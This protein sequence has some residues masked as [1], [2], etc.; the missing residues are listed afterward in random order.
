MNTTTPRNTSRDGVWSSLALVAAI[1]VGGVLIF[2][3]YT[4]ILSPK[5]FVASVESY[6][7]LPS[8]A[9]LP[10][11]TGLIGL[12]IAL[13]LLLILGPGRRVAA[14]I[15][16]PL[17]LMFIAMVSYAMRTGLEECGCFGEVLKMEPRQELFVDLV[18]LGLTGLVLW[19]GRSLE[20]GSRLVAPTLGW[21][22][23]V[24][25]AA[26]FLAAGPAVSS[27]EELDLRWSDLSVLEQA[28]P[29]L[30]L[31]EDA[32]LFFFAADCDHCWAFAGAV[33]LMH[34]RVEGLPVHAITF[35]DRLSLDA[36]RDAFQPTY[37]IHVLDRAVFDRLVATYPAGV[38]IQAG[39]I[40]QTWAGFVPSHRQIAES[41]GYL[42]RETPAA[43]LG[44][45]GAITEESPT[46]ALPSFGGTLSGRSRQ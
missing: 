25:G 12:E 26:I 2:S 20:L 38:W 11:T 23:L 1:L 19:K 32:F 15:T 22:G 31:G 10:G 39:G 46:S 3:A 4:K 42:Y 6:G 33:Q 41:G 8:W 18:L 29:P 35:S 44:G 17:V 37:P 7:L 16:L 45:E 40:S 28:Q 34:D 43:P 9:L 24:V 5:A 14:W 21:G 36:F 30:V 27:S 13:G